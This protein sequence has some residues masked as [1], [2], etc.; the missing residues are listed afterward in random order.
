MDDNRSMKFTGLVFWVQDATLSYK[1][2]KKLGFDV[3]QVTDRDATV[4]CENLE[5]MLVTMRD[6]DEFNGDSLNSQKGKGMYV[7][8]HTADVDAK[9]AELIEMGLMPKAEPR[10]WPWGNREFVIADPD[11]YKTCFWQSMRRS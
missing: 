8:I 4:V 3:S 11:G 6:E 5:I 9:Y 10:D 2:Y 7:Y 1:F